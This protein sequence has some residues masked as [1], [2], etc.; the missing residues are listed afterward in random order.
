MYAGKCFMVITFFYSAALVFCI[1]TNNKRCAYDT[2]TIY[3]DFPSKN[4][5]LYIFTINNL[6]CV[7]SNKVNL[8]KTNID[9]NQIES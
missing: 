1:Y 2:N 8:K 3:K 9:F 4:T 6:K 5:K 7:I